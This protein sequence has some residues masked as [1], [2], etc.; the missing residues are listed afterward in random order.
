MSLE[1]SINNLAAALNNLA[2]AINKQPQEVEQAVQVEPTPE[3]LT[4]QAV[5]ARC[6]NMVR[7]DA[8]TKSKIVALLDSFNVKT[9]T[10]LQEADLQKFSDALDA[11]A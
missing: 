2:K 4:H 5:S 7:Q 11:L 3:P 6:L 9:V 10:K 1:S 8:T